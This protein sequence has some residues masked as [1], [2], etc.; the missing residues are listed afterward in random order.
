M[1]PGQKPRG[2]IS[3]N[4]AQID[5]TFPGQASLAV[6][7]YIVHSFM[8]PAKYRAFPLALVR[9]ESALFAMSNL[10][11]IMYHYDVHFISECLPIHLHLVKA[12]HYNWGNLIEF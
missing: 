11:Q 1:G 5:Q 3:H 12:F 6:Y 4:V 10:S 2:Q 9:T 7:Q 8:I